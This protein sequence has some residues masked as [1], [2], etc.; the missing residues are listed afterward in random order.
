MCQEVFALC[1]A[2]KAR[3]IRCAGRCRAYRDAP[4]PVPTALARALS[5]R[6]LAA[7][8]S[9]TKS[10][11]VQIVKTTS[12]SFF[13]GSVTSLRSKRGN[14]PFSWSR[15]TPSE[16]RRCRPAH[17]NIRSISVTRAGEIVTA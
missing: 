11:E 7:L 14:T 12:N 9:L 1:R 5:W 16:R 2:P 3:A 10:N 13:R 8:T 17:E 15:R 4:P 6:L